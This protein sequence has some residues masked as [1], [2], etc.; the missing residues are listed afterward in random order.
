MTTVATP[1]AWADDF[2][3]LVVRRADFDA[4]SGDLLEE[5]RDRIHPARGQAQAD[6]WYVKQI[7]GFAVRTV[8]VWGALFGAAI[9]LR[10]ALDWFVPTSD[11]SFRSAMSTYFGLGLLLATGFWSA[12]RSGES[13]T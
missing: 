4:I 13:R 8:G 6:F 7:I 3:R 10:T 9:V 11:F 1:P 12:W 2:L 5:Y